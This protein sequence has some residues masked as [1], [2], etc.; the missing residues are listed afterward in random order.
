MK[1]AAA[2]WMD[3]AEY[4]IKSAEVMLKSGRYFYVVFMCHLAIEETL[5][6]IWVASKKG[7]PP[8][9]HRL[10]HL[11]EQ[12]VNKKEI[13]DDMAALIKELDDKSLHVL[14]PEGRLA[15]A[16]KVNREYTE[17][18]FRDTVSTLEWL[19]SRF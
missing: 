10:T 18:V 13:P 5:K 17:T 7:L 9:A 1:K 15:F 19:K 6:A 11:S 4:D 16:G 8:K 2:I 3:D 12:L 14:Y